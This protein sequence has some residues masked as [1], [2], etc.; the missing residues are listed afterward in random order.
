MET[1]SMPDGIFLTHAHIGHYTGLMDLGREAMGA[2]SAIV[3]AMPKM[4][5]YLS[6]NGPWSQLVSLKN[7]HLLPLQHQ[8]P[9]KCTEHL[10]VMPIIVPHRDEFSETVGFLIS[11]PSKRMLFIPDIDKWGKWDQDIKDWITKVDYALLDGTFF[12]NGE[13][14]GRD[15]SQIPHPFIEES[16]ELFNQMTVKEK[17]KIYFIHLNHTNPLLNEQSPEYKAFV[18]SDFNV[19]YEGQI[20]DL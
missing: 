15:M 2:D 4:I 1:Q 19:T 16:T 5:D 12:R 13:I 18:K 20:F 14:F 3:Y 10:S 9:Q 7:I 11:G 17:S 6:T 8:T